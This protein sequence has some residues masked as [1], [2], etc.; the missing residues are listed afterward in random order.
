MNYIKYINFF[1]LLL[2]L[3]CSSENIISEQGTP[4]IDKILPDETWVGDTLTI[5]GTNFGDPSISNF[6]KLDEQNIINSTQCLKWT[7]SQIK[8][9]VPLTSTSGIVVI[10]GQ[11]TSNLYPIVIKRLPTIE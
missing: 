5:Y 7:I 4:V 1:A 9:I 10:V 2:L 8:I 6:I 3:S 11:D